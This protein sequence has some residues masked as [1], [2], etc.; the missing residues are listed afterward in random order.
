MEAFLNE[1]VWSLAHWP[2]FAAAVVFM[3]VGQ[4]MKSSVWTRKRAYTKGKM[5][6]LF[7]WAYKTMPLH[8]VVGGAI[9]G[10]VWSKPEASVEGPAAIFY[11]AFAGALSVWLYQ[12]LKGIAKRR[13][14]EL[15]KL[16][17]QSD[18]PPN[19]RDTPTDKPS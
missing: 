1:H 15:G 11:F 16:P 14:I 7:W 10:L 17:G 13:G 3:I 4:V 8:P 6:W 19:G 18:A 9:T 5:Q 12:I 2:F